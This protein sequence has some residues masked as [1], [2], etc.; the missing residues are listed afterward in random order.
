LI[1]CLAESNRTPFDFSEGESELVSGF[2]TEYRGGLFSLIFI[3]EYASILFLCIFTS[4]Y[5]LGGGL[6]V[7]LKAFFVSFFYVW[8]RGS[9]PRLRYD[10]LIIIF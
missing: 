7:M 5:F 2:N 6:S 1:I 3:R 4:V 8:V 10:K 9:F